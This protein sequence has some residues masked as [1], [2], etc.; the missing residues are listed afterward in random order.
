M[1]TTFF[2]SMNNSI[3]NLEGTLPFTPKH[4]FKLSGSYLMPKIETDFGVRLRYHSG[5]PILFLEDFPIIASWNFDAPPP[6]AVIDPSGTPI[7]VGQDPNNL[8]FL[9][10]AT[11]LDLR[12]A[13]AF[14]FGNQ[15]V[16]VSIDA[17]NIFPTTE[18]SPMPITIPN[19]EE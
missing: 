2:S 1:D 17:F 13:K 18:A 9:P 7:L 3:N 15:S 11:I 14:N 10:S 5:R 12:V 6:N 19:L 16:Q 4:E 8:I